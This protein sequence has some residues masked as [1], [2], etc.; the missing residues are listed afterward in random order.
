MLH[1]LSRPGYSLQLAGVVLLVF[2]VVSV[3]RSLSPFPTSDDS[4]ICSNDQGARGIP[5]DLLLTDPTYLIGNHEVVPFPSAPPLCT[6]ESA[7]G[8]HAFDFGN[9]FKFEI[10]RLTYDVFIS[11]KNESPSELR[12]TT[13]MFHGLYEFDNKGW[14]LKP[15]IGLG[16]GIVDL[17]ARP[18]DIAE[19]AFLPIHQLTGGV[20]YSITQKLLGNLEYRWSPGNSPSFGIEG[21]PAEFQLK[22]GGFRVGLRY[23]LQ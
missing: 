7:G 11:G 8:A 3:S 5:Q 17:S 10:E 9:G 18:S 14:Q 12:T 13:L 20:N 15:Y 4:A 23:R 22:G 6:D 21:I 19:D 16:F 1:L 2:V